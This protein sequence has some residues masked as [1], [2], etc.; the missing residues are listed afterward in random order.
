LTSQKNHGKDKGDGSSYLVSDRLHSALYFE[1]MSH[2]GPIHLLLLQLQNGRMT[3]TT[4]VQSAATS[5]GGAR[6]LPPISTCPQPTTEESRNAAHK[7]TTRCGRPACSLSVGTGA[8]A[9]G[10]ELSVFQD[11]PRVSFWVFF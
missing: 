3:K 9:L 6:Q 4:Q 8:Q 7:Y 5:R 11:L 1:N 10:P 2:R